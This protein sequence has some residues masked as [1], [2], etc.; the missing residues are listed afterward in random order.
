MQVCTSIYVC[1]CVCVCVFVCVCE[2]FK[3]V[4][5]SA[6]HCSQ[7][8]DCLSS[9]LELGSLANV[10]WQTPRPSFSCELV[11]L[12]VTLLPPLFL[13]PVSS[14]S[15]RPPSLL[16]VTDPIM[17]MDACHPVILTSF[18]SYFGLFSLSW[19]L[20]PVLSQI[21]SQMAH[22]SIFTG[23][24]VLHA[25]PALPT[26]FISCH[27]NKV[28]PSY[29]HKTPTP[30]T[31]HNTTWSDDF[32]LCPLCAVAPLYYY[33]FTLRNTELKMCWQQW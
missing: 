33:I 19:V 3:A 6:L 30:S 28:F 15:F 24:L 22:I 2:A 25:W 29:Q 14:S 31:I 21:L 27:S 13:L 32:I 17:Y 4:C 12:L 7:L 11:S 18:H 16:Q 9:P 20:S 1:V 23:D 10:S 26:W 8:S 5:D